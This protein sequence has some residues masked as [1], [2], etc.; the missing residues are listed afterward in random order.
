[1]ICTH[2]RPYKQLT[3]QTLR[4]SGYTGKIYLIVD[5]EDDTVPELADVAETYN[6]EIKMFDKEYYFQ[7]VDKG[8]NDNHRACILYA[9]GFCEDF[10]K[11]LGLDAFII[12]DDDMTGFRHRYCEGDVLRSMKICRF[13]A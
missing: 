3:L 1:M 12:A 8:T 4:N 10:A 13:Y 2:G 5:N 9:K 11:Y 7:T 6:A